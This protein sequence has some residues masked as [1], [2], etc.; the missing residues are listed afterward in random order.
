M[1]Y[2]SKSIELEKYAFGNTGKRA[3]K[4]GWREFE[5]QAKK[6][7]GSAFPKTCGSEY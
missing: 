2:I 5:C 3:E 1:W 4:L 6:C 7:H